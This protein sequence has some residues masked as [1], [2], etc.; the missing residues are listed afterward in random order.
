MAVA[1]VK[2]ALFFI[3]MK[4][5]L[6]NPQSRLDLSYNFYHNLKLKYLIISGMEIL[7]ILQIT[8]WTPT[9]CMIVESLVSKANG[10]RIMTKVSINSVMF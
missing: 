8:L 4:V 6:W 7:Y 9:T 10:K 3:P 5:L 2:V 1:R